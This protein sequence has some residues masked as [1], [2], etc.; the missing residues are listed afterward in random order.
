MNKKFGLLLL[1][2]ALSTLACGKKGPPRPR[3]TQVDLPQHHSD[4]VQPGVTADA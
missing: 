2:I 4:V 1:V 3:E